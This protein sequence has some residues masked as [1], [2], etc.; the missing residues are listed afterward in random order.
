MLPYNPAIR[1]AE[2]EEVALF[3]RFAQIG[4]GSFPEEW[5]MATDGQKTLQNVANKMGV[6]SIWVQRAADQQAAAVAQMQQLIG[7]LPA[8]PPA[9]PQGGGAPP[10]PPSAMPQG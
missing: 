2:Q 9:I 4:A 6:N 7:G 3:A 1:S 5:K 10:M 8:K